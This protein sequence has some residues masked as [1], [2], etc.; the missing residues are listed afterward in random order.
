MRA[1]ASL[2]W[3]VA[4]AVAF[5]ATAA[6]AVTLSRAAPMDAALTSVKGADTQH[7]GDTRPAP[8]AARCTPS[9]LRIS[10]GAGARVTSVITRYPVDFTNVSD[11]PCTLAGYPEVTPYRG[12]GGL[13]GPAAGHDPSVVARRV[14]LGPGQTAH[15]ALDSLVPAT[16]CRPVRVTGLRVA[17]PGQGAAR[18]VRRTLTTCAARAARG[19]EYLR[20]GAV[21][22]GPGTAAPTARSG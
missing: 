21:R 14:L 4:T 7:V 13:V 20:V 19:Q 6:L 16:R 15:A 9:R 10:A 22:P 17:A 11:A 12:S 2:V 18:Y 3:R 1:G 8:P 5:G